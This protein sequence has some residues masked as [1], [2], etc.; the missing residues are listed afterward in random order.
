[1]ETDTFTWGVRVGGS[2]SLNVGTLQAQFG[3]GYKQIASTGINSASE[4]WNLSHQGDVDDINP[5]RAFL[6]S[7][8]TSSFW[9]TNPWGEKHLY[10][11]KQD[12]VATKWITESFVE[13]SFTFE[14][15]FAP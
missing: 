6:K 8:V 12:S 9:W 1:M 15:A 10:R 2:E 5:V 14:Q 13:I 3:D 11:V 7:H 4:T